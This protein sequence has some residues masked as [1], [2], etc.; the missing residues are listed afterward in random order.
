MSLQ[1]SEQSAADLSSEAIERILAKWST[2]E[3]TC[4]DE[5]VPLSLVW[6]CD[7][8]CVD[9]FGNSIAVNQRRFL[10]PALMQEAC[11]YIV[12]LV[13]RYPFQLRAEM[14]RPMFHRFLD[15][16]N[17]TGSRRLALRAI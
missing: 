13:A 5:F 16:W 3:D 10:P 4:R 2:L 15:V 11:D 14:A 17:D 9:P 1:E 7:R 12:V 8:D 6:P